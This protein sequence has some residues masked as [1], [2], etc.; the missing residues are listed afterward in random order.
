MPD[1][2]AFA[3]HVFHSIGERLSAKA[4]ELE[5]LV[6][7]AAFEGWL[8]GEALLACKERQSSYPFSEVAA[9]PTYASEG[10]DSEGGRDAGDLRVGG[11][12]GGANH[13]WLF[14]E[15]VLV[16]DEA[17]GERKPKV[18]AAVERLKG[19]GWKKSAALLI[20]VSVNRAG[21]TPGGEVWDRPALTDPVVIA[22]PGGGTVVARAYDVKQNPADTLRP[23]GQ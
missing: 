13:C 20:A 3:V 5:L 17:G 14:A 8:V 15:F 21:D 6:G 23:P 4:A 2:Y 10:V 19:L 22:L 11:P 16:G 9:K 1:S 18:E 12:D 7:T